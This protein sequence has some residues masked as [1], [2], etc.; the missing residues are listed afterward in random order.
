MKALVRA[1]DPGQ[2]RGLASGIGLEDFDGFSF[3]MV[4]RV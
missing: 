4:D 1:S 3:S 2:N